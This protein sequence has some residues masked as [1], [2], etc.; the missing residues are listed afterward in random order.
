M[1]TIDIILPAYNEEAGISLFA[2]ELHSVLDKL[3]DRYLFRVI[4]VLDRS[5]DRSLEVLTG[6]VHRYPDTT[7]LHLSR[8]F[9]HQMSLVAGMDHSTGDAVIMMDCDMQHPPELI[10]TLIAEWENGFDI[11]HTLR[12]YDEKTPLLKRLTSDLFYRVQNSLSPVELKS[13]V[14][15]FRL[16]SRAV[17]KV[18]QERIREHNQFLRG[19]FQWIGYSSTYV[20]FRCGQRAAGETK[21]SLKYLLLF[22]SDG[23]VSFSRLPLRIAVLVGAVMT[24]FAMIYGLVLVYGFFAHR[25]F[26]P[27]YTS[28]MVAFLFVGGVQ[29]LL[30]GIIGEYVGHIFDEVKGRPLYVVDQ[31]IRNHE[32]P[33]LP[34]M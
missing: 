17:V 21:Y 7:V 13:G 2:D 11:V 28:L 32:S 22:F 12:E 26:P 3:R 33:S 23:I 9:G 6:I 29:L 1:K 31:V 30:M 19:L 20:S 18:F 8:R 24:S 25:G 10:P 15:D 27:G 4:F 5:R 14:A 34:C 16:I